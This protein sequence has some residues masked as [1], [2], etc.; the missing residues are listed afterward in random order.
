MTEESFPSFF[1][2]QGTNGYTAQE[3]RNSQSC[4]VAE[5]LNEKRQLY[6]CFLCL[7]AF[8]LCDV[9]AVNVHNVNMQA[10]IR[11]MFML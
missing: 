1:G 10:F 6:K 2:E 7:R 4:H 9:F 3:Q 11:S 8:S 5:A